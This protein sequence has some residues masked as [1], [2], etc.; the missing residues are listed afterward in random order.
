[1]CV[2]CFLQGHK[3][4]WEKP[5]PHLLYAPMGSLSWGIGSSPILTDRVVDFKRLSATEE[6]SEERLRAERAL[7]A[8]MDPQY[9]APG[10]QRAM[11]LPVFGLPDMGDIAQVDPRL[12]GVRIC[13][14]CFQAAFP[15]DA[16]PPFAYEGL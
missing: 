1:M 11:P 6:G 8:L 5:Q 13:R 14:P 16:I 3:H 7:L 15:E 9:R 12:H 4:L 2:L 10:V